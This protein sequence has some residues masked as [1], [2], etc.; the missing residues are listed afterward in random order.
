M[1]RWVHSQR[2][3]HSE[4]GEGRGGGGGGRTTEMEIPSG[5]S[6]NRPIKSKLRSAVQII[7]LSHL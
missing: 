6:K 4:G 7:F 2:V 1:H 5:A 3:V